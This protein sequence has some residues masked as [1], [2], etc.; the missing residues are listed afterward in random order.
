VAKRRTTKEPPASKAEKAVK[1]DRAE[2]APERGK[3]VVEVTTVEARPLPPDGQADA[4]DGIPADWPA[5]RRFLVGLF[6]GPGG[7]D[8]PALHSAKARFSWIGWS[9][10]GAFVGL[11]LA[12]TLLLAQYAVPGIPWVLW[13]LLTGLLM[14]AGAAF[15]VAARNPVAKGGGAFFLLTI[16]A[17]VFLLPAAL[18][19]AAFRGAKGRVAA[20]K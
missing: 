2:R 9:F 17:L 4:A 8:P 20:G 3:E 15:V 14:G 18:V 12:A 7:S 19:F 10:V 16:P 6:P 5:W 11:L 1:T 13:G